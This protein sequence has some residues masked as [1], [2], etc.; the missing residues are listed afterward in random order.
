MTVQRREF[1]SVSLIFLLGLTSVGC[2]LAQETIK[3]GGKRIVNGERADLKDNLWQ[4]ALIVTQ[5]DGLSYLCGGSL[6]AQK[7]VLTAAH[8]FGQSPDKSNALAIAGALDWKPEYRAGRAIEAAR[9]IVHD[10][11]KQGSQENDLALVKLKSA[12]NG[13]VIVLASHSL[14]IPVGQRLDVTGWGAMKEG[15]DLSNDLQ[16]AHVPYMDPAV[17][18]APQA[19][20]GRISDSMICAGLQDGGV[21]SCQGDSGGPLVWRKDGVPT[22]VGVV[23][24]GEGCARPLKYGVYTRVSSYRAW[25]QSVEAANGLM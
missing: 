9:I 15:G 14:A 20:N 1:L 13:E 23:S 8:C 25:I 11:Y 2:P 4:V 5:S 6:V 24:F 19:Y 7:W 3:V 18:N 21:D 16:I 22:L 10:G 12:P 17:C